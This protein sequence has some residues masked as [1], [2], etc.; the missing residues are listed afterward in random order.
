[1]YEVVLNN[2]IV[3]KKSVNHLSYIGGN[4]PPAIVKRILEKVFTNNLA[5]KCNWTGKNKKT[6]LKD[7]RI[8]KIIK[9]KIAKW[10]GEKA[11]DKKFDNNV[12]ISKKNNKAI[13]RDGRIKRFFLY[14]NVLLTKMPTKTTRRTAVFLIKGKDTGPN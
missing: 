14:L 2:L 13:I 9:E 3:S 4:K 7:L 10:L 6:S 11:A 12:N 1:M 8:V 5:V